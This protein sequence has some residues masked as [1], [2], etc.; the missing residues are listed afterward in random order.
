[1]QIPLPFRAARSAQLAR[2]STSLIAVG[3]ALL[4]AAM[5]SPAW[6]AVSGFALVALGATGVTTTQLK[7]GPEA[8][9]LLAVH[10]FTYASLFLLFVGATLHA[11]ASGPAVGLQSGQSLDLAASLGPMSLAAWWTIAAI[12]RQIRG[13]DATRA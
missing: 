4:T 3:L 5:S 11:S 9:P 7:R 12:V 8:V 2:H 10:L 13:E 1:M 6:P